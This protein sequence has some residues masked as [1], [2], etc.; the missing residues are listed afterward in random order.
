MKFRK[1]ETFDWLLVVAVFVLGWIV[2]SKMA[3]GEFTDFLIMELFESLFMAIIIVWI[4]KK[5]RLF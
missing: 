2:S 1:F 3:A 5:T 4:A